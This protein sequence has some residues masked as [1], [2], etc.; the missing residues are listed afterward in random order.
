M[1]FL[2]PA[3]AVVAETA[4]AVTGGV[5]ASAG[6]IGATIA[7]GTTTV[8]GIVGTAAAGAATTIG[9]E[10]AAATTLGTVDI[11]PIIKDGESWRVDCENIVT[12]GYGD[13]SVTFENENGVKIINF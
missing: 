11:I 2:L 5:I 9:I 6:T 7:A 8:G 13:N 1:F 4:A 3:L 10:T 12:I